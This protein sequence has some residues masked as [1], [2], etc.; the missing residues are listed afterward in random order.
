MVV[1]PN[2]LVCASVYTHTIQYNMNGYRI[3]GHFRQV[4]FRYGEPENEKIYPRKSVHSC[5][6]F[7][8]EIL[9]RD[10]KFCSSHSLTV[11]YVE[12]NVND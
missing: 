3:A 2:V 9:T 12:L 1:T 11:C 8:V 10:S 4:L 7:I 6:V 5:T